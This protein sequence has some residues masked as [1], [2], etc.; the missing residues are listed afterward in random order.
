MHS[1]PIIVSRALKAGASGYLLKDTSPQEL[2]DA[3]ETVRRGEHYLAGDVAMKVALIG[4]GGDEL[5]GGYRTFRDLTSV[6]RFARRTRWVPRSMKEAAAM[7]PATK[8]MSM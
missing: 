4:S 3:F 1:D 8:A 6:R 2:V 7:N 5:F